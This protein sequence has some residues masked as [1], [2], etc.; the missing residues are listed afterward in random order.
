MNHPYENPELPADLPNSRHQACTEV[1]KAVEDLR[2]CMTE[3]Q[4][5]GNVPLEAALDFHKTLNDILLKARELQ[6]K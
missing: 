6:K 2:C 3:Q 4:K 1:I 5:S